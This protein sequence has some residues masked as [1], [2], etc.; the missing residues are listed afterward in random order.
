MILVQTQGDSS[1]SRLVDDPEHIEARNRSGVFGGLALRVFEGRRDRQNGADALRVRNASVLND[2]F[3][4]LTQDERQNFFRIKE[5][6]FFAPADRN[7]SCLILALND[8]ER[9]V[10]EVFGQVRAVPF[11][12]QQSLHTEDNFLWW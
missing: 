11:P 5:L 3:L 7:D 1:C 8:P 12:S 10:P 6:L 9:E 4:E 2:H